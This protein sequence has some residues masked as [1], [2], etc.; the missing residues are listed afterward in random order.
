MGLASALV[1]L[2][3]LAW[4]AFRCRERDE[5]TL[6]G[7]MS[8]SA[9]LLGF[10][11]LVHIPD[12]WIR[13]HLVLFTAIAAR[14]VQQ[15]AAGDRSLGSTDADP[16]DDLTVGSDEGVPEPPVPAGADEGVPEP[17]G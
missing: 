5:R 12:G 14:S 13:P 3:T 10:E 8:L 2:V 6:L 16:P 1:I 11:V 9:V 17:T 4:W 7:L 15:I